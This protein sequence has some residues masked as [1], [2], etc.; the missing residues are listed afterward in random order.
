M[1][2]VE[3]IDN[4]SPQLTI[5]EVPGS[6]AYLEDQPQGHALEPIVNGVLESIMGPSQLYEVI[7]FRPCPLRC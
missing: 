2:P 1:S 4:F 6:P 3:I 7:L 5:E